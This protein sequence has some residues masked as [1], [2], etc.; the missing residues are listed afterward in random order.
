MISDLGESGS[1]EDGKWKPQRT[2][3]TPVR[4]STYSFSVSMRSVSGLAFLGFPSADGDGG[5]GGNA[6]G[7]G[8]TGVRGAEPRAFRDGSETC[9]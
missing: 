6:P 2:R 8:V 9:A 7:R 1:K 4:S 5:A 3:M